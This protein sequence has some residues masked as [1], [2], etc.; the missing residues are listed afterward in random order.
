MQG[1]N[2]SDFDKPLT[3]HLTSPAGHCFHF[4]SKTVL[5]NIR[6]IAMEFYTVIYGPQ[7]LNPNDFGIS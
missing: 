3:F 2:C 4:S 5:A 7:Q 1:M 6:W